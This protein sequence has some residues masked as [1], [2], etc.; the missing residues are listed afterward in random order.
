MLKSDLEGIEREREPWRD[1][2]ER[3]R[4]GFIYIGRYHVQCFILFIYF[5][6]IIIKNIKLLGLIREDQ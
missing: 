6:I 5:I 4:N 1:G 2:S 3:Y